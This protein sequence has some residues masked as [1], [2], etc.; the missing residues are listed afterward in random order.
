M[1][2]LLDHF[3]TT[4]RLRSKYIRIT[5]RILKDYLRATSNS[6]SKTT[7]EL[8]KDYFKTFSRIHQDWFKSI[9]KSSL[10]SSSKTFCGL[11]QAQYKTSPEQLW[12]LI[13]TKGSLQIKKCHKK[14]KKSTSKK[15]QKVQN[16][17]F[18]LFD[19]KGGEAIFSFFPQM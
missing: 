12:D 5:T 6:N 17:K 1:R 18:G 11:H 9:S 2:Q 19:K 16:S 15:H 7:A 3:T 10:K 8:F 4:L 13:T 14:W